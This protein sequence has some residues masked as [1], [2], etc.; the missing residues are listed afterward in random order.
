[1]ENFGF[2]RHTA[3]DE[4]KNNPN[5]KNQNLKL[6]VQE[7]LLRLG[8]QRYHKILENLDRYAL[9]PLQA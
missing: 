4:P 1:M 5:S 3:V 8:C 9:L 7:H 6:L 2:V